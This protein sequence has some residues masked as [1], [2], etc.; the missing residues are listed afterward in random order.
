[1]ILD[2]LYNFVQI[3][4]RK[5]KMGKK[6]HLNG[7]VIFKGRRGIQIG[8]KCILNS[9]LRKNALTGFLYT[10]IGTTGGGSVIIGNNVGISNSCI[11]S[12]CSI[13]IEDNVKI[14]NSCTIIDTDFHSIYS[15]HRNDADYIVKKP[16]VIKK[17]A[18]I[19]C[20]SIILK[21]VVIG[22][23][24]VVAAGSV[25]TKSIP[26]NEVWGGNPAKFLKKI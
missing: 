12:Q 2:K 5:V 20:N 8:D 24:S 22:E 17:N 7:K 26:D 15:E 11:S 21:G 6:C 18:W 16:I 4:I 25:V 10:S 3:K 13:T 1:M 23:N 14:G 9:G 19:G